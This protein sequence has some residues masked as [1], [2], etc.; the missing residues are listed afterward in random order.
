MGRAIFIEKSRVPQIGEAI[1]LEKNRGPQIG[2]AIFLE[3][4]G[5]PQI[6]SRERRGSADRFSRKT[7]VRR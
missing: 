2:E 5:G 4:N 1:F 6:I 7:E 3:K